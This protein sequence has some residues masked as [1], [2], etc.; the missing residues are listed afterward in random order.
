MEK[1]PE[2]LRKLYEDGII[3]FK[4]GSVSELDQEKWFFL[5]LSQ[6]IKRYM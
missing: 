3:N 4:M 1:T 5:C 2:E 6:T